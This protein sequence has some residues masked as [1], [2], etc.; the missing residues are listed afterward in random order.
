MC[1]L[2]SPYN[3]GH[4]DPVGLI[5]SY[6]Y[7]EKCPFVNQFSI[8]NEIDGSLP[9]LDV[10]WQRT[11]TSLC[12]SIYRKPTFV[13]QYIPNIFYQFF[14]WSFNPTSQ[15]VNLISCLVSWAYKIC[16]KSNFHEEIINILYISILATKY[17]LK[18]KIIWSSRD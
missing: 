16:S 5:D 1:V 6:N 17:F 2:G 12:T 3:L 10:F 15:K 7:L 18:I 8:K 13:G 4:C 9:V 11:F 14:W